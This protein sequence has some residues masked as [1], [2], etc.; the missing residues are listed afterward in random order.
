[1]QPANINI[2]EKPSHKKRNIL[3]I[4]AT[5]FVIIVLIPILILGWM[6]L[7][8]GLSDL[9]GSSKPKDL[10]VHYNQTDYNSY[11]QKTNIELKPYNLAPVSVFNS[12]EKTL[13]A[14]PVKT[15]ILTLSE[16]EL[17]AALNNLGLYWLP[18]K[19]IQ[20]KINEGSLEISG[21]LDSS[22]INSFKTYLNRNGNINSDASN[23]ID[24][25]RRFSNDAPIY[26]KASASI[27]DNILKFNLDQAQIGR[28]NIP[29]GE[30]GQ[31]LA[32]SPYINVGAINFD[33]K[34]VKLTNGRLEFI[35]TYPS[36]IYIK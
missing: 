28:L 8:P 1:M 33:A 11:K 25:A 36:V 9:M 34:Q 5:I 24:W 17:T 13:L 30:L 19:N 26:L 15:N 22:K 29:L 32:D 3:I 31:S 23:S 27:T 35:G 18:V 4:V 12:N 14:S 6:G 7:V 16:S 10:G 21:S 2:F 20:T